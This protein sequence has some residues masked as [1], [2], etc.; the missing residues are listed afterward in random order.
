MT[1][2]KDDTLSPRIKEKIG[3]LFMLGFEGTTITPQ[4]KRLITEFYVGNVILFARNVKNPSQ[5][6]KL[7]HNLQTLR[8]T[9][10]PTPLLIAVDQEGGAVTRIFKKGLIFPGNMSLGSLGSKQYAYRVGKAIGSELNALGINLNLSPVLDIN[11][12]PKN[13]GIGVRALSD[14]PKTVSELGRALISGMQK[15]GTSACAKHFPGKGDACLDAHLFL[16]TIYTPFKK[17]NQRELKPFRAAIKEK[18]A[19]IMVSHVMY[20]DYDPTHPASISKKINSY[21]L[22]KKMNFQGLILTDDL[23]MKAIAQEIGIPQATITSLK[24]GVDIVLICHTFKQQL[25]SIR[26]VYQAVAAGEITQKEL[27][28]KFNRIDKI[29]QLKLNKKFKRNRLSLKPNSVKNF[30]LAK[31]IAEKAI[32]LVKNEDNLIPIKDIKNKQILLLS[33][34]ISNLTLVEEGNEEDNFFYQE[35]KKRIPQLKEIKIKSNPSKKECLETARKIKESQVN[36]VIILTYN[37]HLIPNQASLV[38]KILNLKIPTIIAA[39]RNPYD[40]LA[41]KKAKHYIVSYG[42]RTISLKALTDVLLGKRKA[43]GK[44]PVKLDI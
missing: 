43:Q 13:P 9:V 15:N 1:K 3:E 34:L 29:K 21:L 8:K 35:F 12:N 16:P 26:S 17:L 18:V 32:T 37:A 22:R 27:N 2:S 40:I 38:K 41:F 36:L 42:F 4:I 20:P 24:N 7:C 23:E 30:L 28:K 33:P 5:L 6:K 44:L 10:S 39:I 11:T 19:A 25:L 31:K 14:D